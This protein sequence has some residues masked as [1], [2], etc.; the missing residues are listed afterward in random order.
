MSKVALVTGGSRGIGA[1]T[2]FKLAQA[3]YSLCINYYSD[4]AA[5]MQVVEKI[6]NIGQKAVAIKADISQEEDVL[7]LFSLVDEQLGVIDLLVNNSLF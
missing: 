3:G 5:A 4:G 1:A 6:Q 7:R 2:A